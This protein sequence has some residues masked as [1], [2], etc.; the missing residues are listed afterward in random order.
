MVDFVRLNIFILHNRI[1]KIEK[2]N[3]NVIN[4]QQNEKPNGITP[5]DTKIRHESN[6]QQHDNS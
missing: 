2:K 3:F 5:K 4:I 6:I 1:K